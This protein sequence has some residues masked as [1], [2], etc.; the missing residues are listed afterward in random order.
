MDSNAVPV[1]HELLGRMFGI[2]RAS[3]T[4]AISEMGASER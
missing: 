3:V 2:R 4:A 1:T